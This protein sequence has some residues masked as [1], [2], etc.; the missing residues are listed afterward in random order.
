MRRTRG[1]TLVE[2]LVA[3]ALVGL[4]SVT[5]MGAF[6]AGHRSVKGMAEGVDANQQLR[7]AVKMMTDDL[8]FAKWASGSDPSFVNCYLANGDDLLVNVCEF[9]VRAYQPTADR[10]NPY[11]ADFP[12]WPGDLTNTVLVRVRYRL[13][14][15]DLVR[16]LYDEANSSRVY[17]SRILVAGLNPYDGSETGSRF[18]QLANGLVQVVLRMPVTAGGRTDVA[19]VSTVF[20]MR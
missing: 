2:L 4:L 16:E 1:F 12:A 20:Y 3:V 5:V 14:D 13:V 7:A 15:G 18:E 10:S 17:S 8:N 6:T 11:W 9:S 19:Q